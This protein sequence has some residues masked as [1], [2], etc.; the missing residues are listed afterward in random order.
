MRLMVLAA[1]VAV[2][3]VGVGC[4]GASESET[5]ASTPTPTQTAEQAQGRWVIRDLGAGPATVGILINDRGQVV[6]HRADTWDP[7]GNEAHEFPVAFF[8]WNGRS[9]ELT[10]GG[11]GSGAYAINERG[12]VV[13]DSENKTGDYHA[14]LW[15]NGKIRDLGTL[16]GTGGY[17]DS[18]A[19]AINERGQVVGS[20]L[21]GATFR[22]GGVTYHSSHAFLWQR[23]KMRDLGTLGG[24]DSEA[25]AIN[26]RGQV[27]GWADTRATDKDGD[28]IPH[29]FL[30][31]NGKMRD[32]G[33]LGGPSSRATTINERGQVIGSA[34][35]KAKDEYGDPIS[36]AFLWQNGKM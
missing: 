18:S 11:Y 33:T 19:H 16:G 26:E 5:S 2:V 3:L 10:L 24:P 1:S 31:Q 9:A 6:W 17:P 30:S 12:Q 21:T 29:A 14:F 22:R 23:G 15:Q 36:H 4:G 27:V 20:A 28:P 35:T 32:L 34:D 13:G 25:V 8:W 7:S